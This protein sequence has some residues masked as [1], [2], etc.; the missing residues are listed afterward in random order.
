VLLVPED[1]HNEKMNT[2]I[3]KELFSKEVILKKKRN[4]E[5]KIN[6]DEQKEI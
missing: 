2:E 6:S 5:R 4:K 1:K 3:A